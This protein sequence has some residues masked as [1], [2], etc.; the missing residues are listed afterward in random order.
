MLE[1][2][3]HDFSYHREPIGLVLE[4]GDTHDRVNQM[5][6]VCCC[7]RSGRDVSHDELSLRKFTRT[8]LVEAQALGLVSVAIDALK[9]V[10]VV[11]IVA[12]LRH[13]RRAFALIASAAFV[14]FT[15]T[16]LLAS[17]GLWRAI[18]RAFR[19]RVKRWPFSL[20]TLRLKS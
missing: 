14:M 7:W 19:A 15:L 18:G 10:L 5:D 4:R 12:A 2:A 13:E 3:L 1:F 8:Q 20:N 17:M 11:S 6:W 16:S 9:A